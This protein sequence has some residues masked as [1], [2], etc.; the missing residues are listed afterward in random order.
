MWNPPVSHEP[1]L[2]ELRQQ[3]APLSLNINKS[4]SLVP[5]SG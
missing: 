5:S 2:D 1:K 4:L 3:I